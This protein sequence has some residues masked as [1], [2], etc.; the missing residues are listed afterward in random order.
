MEATSEA[1][2]A[3]SEAIEATSGAAP[4]SAK[5]P[6]VLR[7]GTY[8]RG[9]KKEKEESPDPWALRLGN[10]LREKKPGPWSILANEKPDDPMVRRLV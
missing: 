10:Y 2:E 9:E 4:D 7:L 3:T 6:W 5:D 8:L 1:V